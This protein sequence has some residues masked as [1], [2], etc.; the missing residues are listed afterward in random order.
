[1]PAEKSPVLWPLIPQLDL[2]H[3]DRI[4]GELRIE[5]A[6]YGV[7]LA[8]SVLLAGEQEIADGTAFAPQHIDHHLGLVRRHDRVLLAL[9]EDH[10]LRQPL[11]VIERRTLAIALH[12]RRIGPDQPIEI[13]RLE[14]VGVASERDRIAHAIVARTTRK[15]IAEHQRGERGVAAGAAAGDDA[16]LRV[17]EALLGQKLRTVHAVV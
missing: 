5:A 13:T 3:L 2:E 4:E 16:A 8:E 9:E 7:G 10:R 17:D 6:P 15:E 1:M 14:L 12:H 11:R